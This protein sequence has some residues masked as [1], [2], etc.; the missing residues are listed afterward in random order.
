MAGQYGGQ[1]VV[2]IDPSKEH[3]TGKDALSVNIASAQAVAKIVRS[4]LGPKGMDKMLVNIMGDI[5]LTNDGA[6]ILE[7]M[8]IEHPTAKMVVEIAKTQEKT[9]GDGT[10]SAVVMA[11]A[12]LEKAQEMMIQGI[13]PTIIIKGFGMAT[14]KALQ[15][16]EEY[17]IPV[18]KDDRE[19]LEKIALTSITGKASEMSSA[20]LAKICVDAVYAIEN[21]GQVN[22]DDDIVITKEI[23]GTIDD[24]KLI[25][26]IAIRKEALHLEMPHRI[27]N[28]KIALIDTELTFSKTATKS[29]LHVDRA[30]QLFE[31]K[32]QEKTNFRKVVQMIIDT[33]ANVVFCSK[34]MDDYAL[35]FFKEAGVYA[36]RR[37]KDEDMEALS[38]STGA[39]LVRNVHDISSED[40][41]FAELVEQEDLHEEKTYIKGFK[42][43]RT[44]TILIKGGSEHV[45]DNVERVFDDALH[46]VKSVF[47][48][49]MIVAGGGASEIE[50]AQKL[51]AYAST[52]GGREQ[53]AINA[54]A[55]AVEEIPRAIADNCGF[56]TIDTLLNLRA[57]HD[58]VKYGGLNVETAEVDNMLEKGVVDPLRV[59][60]QAIKSAAEVA[61]M[62]LR[63][64]DMLRAREQAMMDVAPE[65]NIHNYDMSGMM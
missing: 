54:F 56:D 33:G 18:K 21:E 3:T 14:E 46:V 4:T 35:H 23:G 55:S 26:G 12:L 15:V 44:M 57:K 47:E 59:K 7:E 61:V 36:T 62:I 16:L 13:H 28:A 65:H 11:G 58:T 60:T 53:M 20:H 10:T 50:V 52:I 31:F 32:E 43:S 27:E 51:R 8:D 49:E 22:V 1:P 2:I 64:D 39:A 48:D 29:K 37:V 41:G 5:T 38:Y 30:E 9:A 24:T 63:V 6:T 40:L 34:N 45:T 17:A 25:N 42:H 19:M